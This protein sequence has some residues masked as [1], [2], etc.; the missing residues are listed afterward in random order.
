MWK[1]LVVLLIAVCWL[2]AAEGALPAIGDDPRIWE[3]HSLVYAMVKDIEEGEPGHFTVTLSPMATL[4]GTFDCGLHSEIVSPLSTWMMVSSIKAAPE[5]G[6]KVLAVVRPKSVEG[7]DDTGADEYL[8][9]ASLVTFMPG[10]SALVKVTGFEDP[11]VAEV[12][13]KIRETRAKGHQQ[14]A[15]EEPASQTGD[16]PHDSATERARG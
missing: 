6:D 8:I 13:E 2:R 12:L 7:E 5:R 1:L 4:S 9:T 14:G 10:G 16:T 3:N 15:E 11:V